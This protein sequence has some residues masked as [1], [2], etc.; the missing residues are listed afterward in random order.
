MKILILSDWRVG[1]VP[2]PAN[3]GGAFQ[4]VVGHIV[5]DRIVLLGN[6]V[7][8]VPEA[9]AAHGDVLDTVGPDGWIGRVS[10]GIKTTWIPG[11]TDGF[12]AE[13]RY[14]GVG[15][16]LAPCIEV[17]DRR[18]M[19]VPAG[20]PLLVMLLD[21]N[22]PR[23]KGR[24]QHGIVDRLLRKQPN[25]AEQDAL[26][27]FR[28]RQWS[29]QQQ[30]DAAKIRGNPYLWGCVH[31][32]SMPYWGRFGDFW[33]GCPGGATRAISLDT[34]NPSRSDLVELV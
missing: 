1:A 32:G 16:K 17:A 20:E 8:G 24:S 12:L 21:S 29:Q 23:F 19:L 3:V 31:N 5:P 14:R 11:T 30:G 7:D 9:I 33:C 25:P 22:S 13:R 15:E 4:R 6:M 10:R 26:L 34:I 27:R 2:L 28:V 18:V